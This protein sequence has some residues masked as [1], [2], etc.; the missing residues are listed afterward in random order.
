[1][2][3]LLTGLDCT[4]TYTCWQIC[5]WF[6]PNYKKMEIVT[7]SLC[8]RT[9]HYADVWGSRHVVAYEFTTQ[10]PDRDE[11]S[12]SLPG[13]CSS[14]ALMSVFI[15]QEAGWTLGLIWIDTKKQISSY[16]E[17]QAPAPTKKKL[18]SYNYTLTEPSNRN[19]NKIQSI[20]VKPGW[21][22]VLVVISS[23]TQPTRQTFY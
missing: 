15:I 14:K 13:C 2:Q 3:I 7:T 5:I 19:T 16:I 4:P 22:G 12:A 17:N 20:N 21:G 11:W 8:H 9:Q 6:P 10:A 1:M 23:Y 18:K